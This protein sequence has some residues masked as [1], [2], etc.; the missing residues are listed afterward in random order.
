MYKTKKGNGEKMTMQNTKSYPACQGGFFNLVQLAAKHVER[1]TKQARKFTLQH[2]TP[3]GGQCEFYEPH[4]SQTEID[5][6]GRSSGNR[7]G[8]LCR[9]PCFKGIRVPRS[10]QDK[11]MEGIP[12]D[13]RR[14]NW[15]PNMRHCPGS[16]IMPKLG[17]AQ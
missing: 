4:R 5:E 17:K 6:F 13:E 2:C 3:R 1:V 9:H 14:L 7:W 11:N 10:T 12:L 15:I 16:S 8:G